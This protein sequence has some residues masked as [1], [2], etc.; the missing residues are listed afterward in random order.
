MIDLIK[1]LPKKPGVYILKSNSEEILYIGKAKDI[2]KRVKDHFANNFYPDN[3]IIPQTA[4]IDFI[5][6]QNES[7]ALILENQLIKKF[8]PKYN[9]LWKDDKNYSFI[10]ITKEDYPR[11]FITHQ[12]QTQKSKLKNQNDKLK[13]KI[14]N[15]QY[16]GPFTSAKELKRNL[17]EI[18]KILPFRSCKNLPKSPCLY[19]DL[20][21]CPGYCVA[22]SKNKAKQITLLLASLFNLISN[23][24]TRLE[25]YDIS[26]ISGQHNVG[27]MVV[28]YGSKKSKKD[29][30]LFKIQK[31][32]DDPSALKE[33]ITRRLKHDE[34]QKP[35]IILLDGGKGQLSKI[36][37]DIPVIALAKLD[38]DYATATLYS[39]FS[40][41]GILVSQLSSDLRNILLQARNEAHR[42]AIGFHRK[43]RQN[44]IIKGK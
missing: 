44:Y 30:R 42:F 33:I 14:T 6:T 34:W 39:K 17:S 23:D 43:K 38:R 5:I 13:C 28:F 26:N 16:I 32:H 29:Y 25:T 4:D 3:Y 35:N 40:K 20:N 31:A 12:P 22:K 8:Q 24:K 9:R 15:H 10:A 11:I 41:N 19:Y 37:I 36:K 27:S 7:K 1:K 18:R 2:Q 21:L